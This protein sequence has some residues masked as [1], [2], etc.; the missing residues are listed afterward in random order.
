MWSISVLAPFLLVSDLKIGGVHDASRTT[1]C[2][3]SPRCPTVLLMIQLLRPSQVLEARGTLT[4][5]VRCGRGGGASATMANTRC[6][7]CVPEASKSE[8]KASVWTAVLPGSADVSCNRLS[9]DVQTELASLSRAR[10]LA[11]ERQFRESRTRIRRGDSLIPSR[12]ERGSTRGEEGQRQ[13]A[14]QGT[15]TL[16]CNCDCGSGW[17]EAAVLIAGVL[18]PLAL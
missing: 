14:S 11:C 6:C 9:R 16:Q 8:Y 7:G 15:N 12:V 1:D 4:P 10:V 13:H 17:P 5:M 3:V 2:K 18:D